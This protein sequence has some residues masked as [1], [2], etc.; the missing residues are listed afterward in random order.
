MLGPFA[1][2]SRRY[3]DIHK[4]SLLLHASYSYS[5]RGVRCPRQRQRQRQQRQRVTEGPLWPRGMGTIT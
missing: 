1:T 2:A 5:A 3:I 4:V